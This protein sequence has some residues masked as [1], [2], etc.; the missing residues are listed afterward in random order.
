MKISQVV[1]LQE[2]AKVRS[3]MGDNIPVIAIDYNKQKITL[4]TDE[5]VSVDTPITKQTPISD[6]ITLLQSLSLDGIVNDD[7][8]VWLDKS[9]VTK[10][11]TLLSK[12]TV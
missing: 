10:I 8:V 5:K 9:D 7:D 6:L 11:K 3:N 12:I 2:L 1:L 4:T